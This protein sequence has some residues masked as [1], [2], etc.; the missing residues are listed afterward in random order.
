MHLA[1]ISN[2]LKNKKTNKAK[3]DFDLNLRRVL[4]IRNSLK[5]DILQMMG[6]YVDSSL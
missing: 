3:T 4:Y 6:K 1:E 5:G 2:H